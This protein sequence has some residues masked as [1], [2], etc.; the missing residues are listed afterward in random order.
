LKIETSYILAG[1]KCSKNTEITAERGTGSFL[2]DSKFFFL[3]FFLILPIY[4]ETGY[5][6]NPDLVGDFFYTIHLKYGGRL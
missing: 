6:G 2:S 5:Y 4:M 1:R 3:K